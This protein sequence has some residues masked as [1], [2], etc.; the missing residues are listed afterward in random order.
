MAK[1]TA[2]KLF[3]EPPEEPKPSE[4]KMI[5]PVKRLDDV[6]PAVSTENDVLI[7]FS[8]LSW[9]AAK[10]DTA[11]KLMNAELDHVRKKYLK[12]FQVDSHATA[13]EGEAAPQTLAQRRCEL[14]AAVCVFAIEHKSELVSDKLKTKDFGVGTIGFKLCPQS[15][16][17]LNPPTEQDPKPL[18]A[19][20][21]VLL[22]EHHIPQTV[23]RKLK[24]KPEGCSRPLSDL[25]RVAYAWDANNITKL[26]KDSLVA[27]DELNTLLIKVDR[28]PERVEVKLKA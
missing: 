7:A 12:H 10:E 6:E 17:P 14:E 1:Q 19:A 16:M 24:A 13:A 5:R 9:L 15:L 3:E 4:P 11:A 23:E 8:E 21:Q 20:L 18:D 27:N 22:Q 28:S 25:I 2:L 26:V